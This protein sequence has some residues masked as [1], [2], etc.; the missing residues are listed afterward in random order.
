MN[1]DAV[2]GHN[3]PQLRLH[4]SSRYVWYMRG[5]HVIAELAVSGKR[6]FDNMPFHLDLLAGAAC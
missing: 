2:R 3:S 1:T 6:H 4:S 5:P